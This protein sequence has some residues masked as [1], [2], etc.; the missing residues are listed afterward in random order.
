MSKQIRTTSKIST[1]IGREN[2]IWN[3]D[4]VMTMLASVGRQSYALVVFGFAKSA[5]TH[6]RVLPHCC[7]ESASGEL[8]PQAQHIDDAS[9]F[10]S[11]P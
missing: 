4:E 11:G 5:R 9:S 3:H 10:H 1:K 6:A 7:L 2:K 8:V